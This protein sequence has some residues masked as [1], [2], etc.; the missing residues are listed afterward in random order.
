VNKH[1]RTLRF[2]VAILQSIPIALSQ[3]RTETMVGDTI[4]TTES[5]TASWIGFRSSRGKGS[6]YFALVQKF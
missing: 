2:G 5:G 3:F 1:A 4:G 6:K